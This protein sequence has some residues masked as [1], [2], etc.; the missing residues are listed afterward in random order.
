[1]PASKV[2]FALSRRQQI[3][4][5]L[6]IVLAEIEGTLDRLGTDYLDV[7]YIHG[8]HEASPLEEALA[9]LNDMVRAGKIHYLG[10]SNVTAWQLILAC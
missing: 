2:F 1:M 9:A 4:L 10:V 7:Y 6:K 3:G 5:S 8:R